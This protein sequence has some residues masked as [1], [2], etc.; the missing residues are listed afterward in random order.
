MV[1][2]VDDG[3]WGG[4]TKFETIIHKLKQLFHI[5]A[6]RKQI[7]EYIGIKLEQKSDFS[8]TI[9][10]KDYTDSIF[11]VTLTKDNYKNPKCK[12]SQTKTTKLKRILWK[13]N[14]IAGMARPE[15]SFFVCE[16]SL[17]IKDATIS[18]LISSQPVKL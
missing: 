17:W 18:H 9:I 10:Q 12:L 5:G 13:I 14:P 8:I 11:S 1:C 7:F 6:E 3:L 16:K 4:N 15:I 2:F